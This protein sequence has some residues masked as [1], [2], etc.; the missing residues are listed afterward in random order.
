MRDSVIALLVV[1]I[2]ILGYFLHSM[3][4]IITDQQRQISDLNAR[5]KTSTLDLQEQC[6]KQAAAFFRA[7]WAKEKLAHYENHYNGKLDRCFAVVYVTTVDSGEV[8]DS[9][10]VFDAFGGTDLGTFITFSTGAKP[11]CFVRLPSGDEKSCT[12][13]KEFDE[14]IKAYM[15]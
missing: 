8:M 4:F 5:P 14:L 13:L 2:G 7:G 3:N 1:A 15:Q 11:R 10:N 9:S 6:A 12:T